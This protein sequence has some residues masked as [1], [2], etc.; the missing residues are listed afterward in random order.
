[1]VTLVYTDS[2]LSSFLSP[3]LFLFLSPRL[4][5]SS[6][7]PEEGPRNL[8]KKTVGFSLS[9]SPIFGFRFRAWYSQKFLISVSDF[10]RGFRFRVFGVSDFVFL[11][12]SISD[13]VFNFFDFRFS[14]RPLSLFSDFLFLIFSISDFFSDFLF[15]EF[16][17]SVFLFSFPISVFLF[18]FSDFCRR[19]A[20]T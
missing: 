18:S 13:F 20:N 17:F 10:V 4:S 19:T 7:P 14:F 1:M 8:L 3:S 2:F 5:L 9:L 15:P 12:F 6:Q 16:S 11:I